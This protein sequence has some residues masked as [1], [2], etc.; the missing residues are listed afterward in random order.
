LT[1]RGPAGTLPGVTDCVV[2]GAG[3]A[4]L[5]AAL[6]LARD[7]ARVVLAEAGDAPGGL[8]RTRGRDGLR[9][10]L[11]GHIP[12]VRDPGRRAWLAALAPDGLLWVPRPVAS[13]RDGRIRPGRYLDQRDG[14][15]EP[16]VVPVPP[17][18][19]AADVLPAMFGTALVERE[20]RVYLEKIDGVP[21]GRIPAGRPLRLMRDQAAPDGFWFP[22]GGI[23]RLMDGMWAA[24]RAAGADARLRTRATAIHYGGGRVRGVTLEGPGGAVRLEVPAVVVALPAAVAVGLLDGDG[25][26]GAPAA[27]GGAVRMRAVCLVYVR[28]A[29]PPLT[30]EAWVQVDDPAV[31]FARMFEMANWD[32]GM[33]TPAGGAIGMECYCDAAP[34]DPLWSLD[35]A[36]LTA[37]CVTGLVRLGWLDDPGRA[38]PLEVVRMPRA[39]P[40]PDLAQMEA[41]SAAPRRLE[42]VAGV[43]LAPGAEVVT[44]IEAGERAAAAVR[45]GRWD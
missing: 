21:L 30:H 2:L 40:L 26:G 41:V 31:P 20:M 22:R 15:P 6:A 14:R 36:A 7:G 1:R 10:D 45:A 38:T 18:A 19:S 5:G 11:G 16:P 34:E 9:Y 44:A 39:Y 35:D 13:V 3:P 29:G 17:D 12:F 28:V 8:C 27:P 43:H 4:G 33:A 32:P 25:R 42:A 37:R 23:G 24:A